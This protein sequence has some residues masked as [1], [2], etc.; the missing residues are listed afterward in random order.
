MFRVA[1]SA[2]QR[3][4][5]KAEAENRVRRSIILAVAGGIAAVAAL[6]AV[7]LFM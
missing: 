7:I 2:A 1:S 4:A 6:E 5:K 3:A